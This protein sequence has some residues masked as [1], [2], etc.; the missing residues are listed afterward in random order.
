M[1]T[2]NSSQ[3]PQPATFIQYLCKLAAGVI[4][5]CQTRTTL[6]SV[7]V[8]EVCDGCNRKPNYWWIINAINSSAAHSIYTTTMPLFRGHH[9]C[10]SKHI[11]RGHVY[12]TEVSFYYSSVR[13]FSIKWLWHLNFFYLTLAMLPF[14]QQSCNGILIWPKVPSRLFLDQNNSGGTNVT[15][16]LKVLRACYQMPLINTQ[17]CGAEG[18]EG[19]SYPHKPYFLSLSVFGCMFLHK[20]FQ[21]F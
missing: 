21:I 19:I 20:T 6:C 1:I 3:H 7:V 8:A 10:E 18:P 2:K 5:W 17:V 15:H 13:L 14:L 12:T 4:N 9:C 16:V 11:K